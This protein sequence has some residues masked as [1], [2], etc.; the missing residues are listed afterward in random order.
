MWF[1]S[2]D[3]SETHSNETQDITD[4]PN[5]ISGSNFIFSDNR[6]SLTISNIVQ[7]R[8]VGEDTDAGRYF[9]VATNPAGVNF[10]YID[11]IV[12]GQF[13]AAS[14]KETKIILLYSLFLQVL[15]SLSLHQ[16]TSLRSIMAAMPSS[17]AGHWPSQSIK[18]SGPLLVTVELKYLS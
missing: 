16:Q 8:R 2:P 1:Y 12:N 11:L 13:T 10:S 6:L 17:Y 15:P 18:S 5:R 9:L 4:M 3:F 7:A 14:Y